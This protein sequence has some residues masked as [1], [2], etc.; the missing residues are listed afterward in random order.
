MESVQTAWVAWARHVAGAQDVHR[1]T[2]VQAQTKLRAVSEDRWSRI[3]EPGLRWP[4]Y[5]GRNY[6]RGG[7]LSVG[8]IH[9][10]FASAGLKTAPE[11]SA[12]VGAHQ[13]WVHGDLNDDEWLAATRSMYRRGLRKGG[14]DVAS[15]HRFYWEQLGETV[16]SVAYTNAARCQWPGKRPT[17]RVINEC[18]RALP[19]TDLLDVLQPRLV[20]C[21]SA[22]AVEQLA[23]HVPVVYV[24]Q[25]R[26]TTVGRH[27]IIGPA[28]TVVVEPDTRRGATTKALIDAGFAAK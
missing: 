25:L 13:R 2:C 6:Q 15:N 1:N 18:L 7:V 12:A 23:P 14:W 5:L 24:H 19:L 10:G 3:A 17:D 22:G 11:V 26:G 27:T 28:R 4:G 8:I 21:N 20:L 9:T 16:D